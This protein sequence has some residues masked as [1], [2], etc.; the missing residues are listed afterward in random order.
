ML[1][2]I[3]ND[4][5]RIKEENNIENSCEKLVR[6]SKKYLTPTSKNDE[7]GNDNLS[8]SS[9]RLARCFSKNSKL[10]K[11]SEKKFSKT[12]KSLSPVNKHSKRLTVNNEYCINDQNRNISDF[13]NIAIPEISSKNSARNYG[14]LRI[15][16]AS[17][18]ESIR[19]KKE[20]TDFLNFEKVEE[21]Y[22]N[23]YGIK[24]SVEK[25]SK[26]RKK[27]NFKKKM[28]YE[29]VMKNATHKTNFLD[30]FNAKD[31]I[32][33]KIRIR[34]ESPN[35][36]KLKSKKNKRVSWN[37]VNRRKK[38]STEVNRSLNSSGISQGSLSALNKTY[39]CLKSPKKSK[40]RSSVKKKKKR[41]LMLKTR[42]NFHDFMSDKD[43][44]LL[45]RLRKPKPAKKQSSCIQTNISSDFIN[46]VLKQND[47]LIL[48]NQDLLEVNQNQFNTI[49]GLKE[50]IRKLVT[51]KQY[52]P[53]SEE[54][55][56]EEKE[57]SYETSFGTCDSLKTRNS[58]F[59][60]NSEDGE[61]RISSK[62]CDGENILRDSNFV[63][64]FEKKF[65]VR[66]LGEIEFFQD[67]ENFKDYITKNCSEEIVKFFEF[68]FKST[69]KK[70]NSILKN[71]KEFQTENKEIKTIVDSLKFE[72]IELNKELEKSLK[73]LEDMKKNFKIEQYDLLKDQKLLYTENKKLLKKVE[74]LENKI[75]GSFNSSPF[76]KDHIFNK[77][78]SP[79]ERHIKMKIEEEETK[80]VINSVRDFN[81]L[82]FEK[83]LKKK[84]LK[85]NLDS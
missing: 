18:K 17:T 35:L 39:T 34:E 45:S 38:N 44:S 30:N 36:T 68:V 64:N 50:E 74:N 83:I 11:C 65:L 14:R 22:Q 2:K 69:Q 49:E 24:E 55:I 85:I 43:Y 7:E 51:L 82:I 37:S 5:K 73:S 13:K 26:S 6:I 27:P 53:E 33:E 66:E 1:R 61:P 3:L 20:K 10:F 62:G 75:K 32:L 79:I 84:I 57:Y 76:T 23:R 16:D 8:T 56:I 60:P 25:K 63:V 48:D 29:N 46:S 47:N 4:L 59:K 42:D 31:F 41:K 28:T 19:N 77:N 12:S 71:L 9:G 15:S 54:L 70:F 40:N 81:F 58:S 72:K 67:L 80:S 21:V 78:P 52:Y